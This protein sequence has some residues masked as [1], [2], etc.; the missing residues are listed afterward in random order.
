MDTALEMRFKYIEVA[1]WPR[2]CKILLERKERI[3]F[4]G[5]IRKLRQNL[6]NQMEGSTFLL[7]FPWTSEVPEPTW[8]EA[9]TVKPWRGRNTQRPL[10]TR[11]KAPCNAKILP[12]FLC[13]GL[14]NPEKAP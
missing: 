9:L 12:L 8:N 7:F 13:P 11:A 2:E 5:S 14:F 3:V 10:G 4:L 1:R 6:W